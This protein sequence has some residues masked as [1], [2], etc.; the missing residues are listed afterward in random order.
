[1][2]LICSQCKREFREKG[3]GPGTVGNFALLRANGTLGIHGPTGRQAGV[4]YAESG[5]ASCG[6]E[7]R[8]AE[9][10]ETAEFDPC[11]ETLKVIN[12]LMADFFNVEKC[13]VERPVTS[14]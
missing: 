7:T 3:T 8:G 11:L 14:H 12:R 13:D 4:V 6:Q 10:N 2:A 5:I 1:M 9:L